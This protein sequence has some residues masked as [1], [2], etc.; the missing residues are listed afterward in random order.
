MASQRQAVDTFERI[1][2]DSWTPDEGH[3]ELL[4]LQR[5]SLG[6]NYV[7]AITSIPPILKFGFRNIIDVFAPISVSMWKSDATQSWSL[8]ASEG[9][10]FSLPSPFPSWIELNKRAILFR[11]PIVIYIPDPQSRE[12]K[13]VHWAIPV[14]L[15][16]ES[17]YVLH[18]LTTMNELPKETVETYLTAFAFLL[19]NCDCDTCRITPVNISISQNESASVLTQRQKDI[20]KLSG[21]GQTY[22]QIGR[23]LGFSE[24]TIKQES[25]KIFRA[26]GV[27]NKAEALESIAL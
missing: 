11:Q 20:L 14:L 6:L 1:S 26:L 7:P 23:R 12:I 4:L 15:P 24:S 5:L 27:H 16:G 18:L 19:I 8:S 25:M 17:C 2:D 10:D 22:A 3:N 21:Q 13:F 9:K